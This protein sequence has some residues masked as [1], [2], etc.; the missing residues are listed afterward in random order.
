MH[1]MEVYGSAVSPQACPD[2]GGRLVPGLA[3]VPEARLLR[4]SRRGRPGSLCS[5]ISHSSPH[6][7]GRTPCPLSARLGRNGGSAHM[8]SHGQPDA[9]A[10]PAPSAQ[11][12]DR[13]VPVVTHRY[14]GQG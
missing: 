7:E 13:Y 3:L 1:A 12:H 14:W 5:G 9:A 8:I 11:E 2:G 6:H 4:R 10:P